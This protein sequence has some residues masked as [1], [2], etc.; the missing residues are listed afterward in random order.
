MAT[1]G[2]PWI[3]PGQYLEIERKA[4]GKSEYIG[5][6]MYAMSGVTLSHDRIV[7]NTLFNLLLHLRGG[8]CEVRSAD[9]RVQIPAFGI[10]TY[11][12]VSVMCGPPQCTDEVRDT[13]TNPCLIVEVLSDS[14]KNYDRGEKFRY[15][16]SLPSFAEYLLLAQ[17]EMRAERHVRQPDGTWVM[18]EF[19]VATD[20]IE[21]LSVGCAV[22]LGD[23]YELVVFPSA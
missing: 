3:T 22:I 20:K 7:V 10:Y 9:F 23:L 6:Q 2:L 19:L 18:R 13:F 5:G 4:D 11:P 12:D 8:P 21:L 1:Q 17:D 16:R 15:Y 14:T